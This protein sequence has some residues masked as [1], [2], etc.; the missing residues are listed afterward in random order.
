MFTS[1]INDLVLYKHVQSK[2][3]GKGR[4]QLVGNNTLRYIID[5]VKGFVTFIPL[6]HGK[7]RT[8][9]NESLNK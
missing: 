4:L 8:H 9:K 3:G 7:L 2:Q 1:H 5:D 6:V